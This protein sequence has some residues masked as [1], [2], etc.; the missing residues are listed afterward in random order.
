MGRAQGKGMRLT[1]DY[2]LQARCADFHINENSTR[3]VQQV[4]LRFGG[5]IELNEENRS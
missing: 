1:P 2:R 4:K 3:A 5:C